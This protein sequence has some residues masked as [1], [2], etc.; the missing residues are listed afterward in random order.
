MQIRNWEDFVRFDAQGNLVLVKHYDG[1]TSER[2]SSAI[3]APASPI[4][5]TATISSGSLSDEDAGDKIAVELVA[6]QTYTWSYRPTETGGIQDPFLKLLGTDGT[7]VIVADDDGG[8]GRSSMISFTPTVGGTY[9]LLATSWYQAD[10]TAPDFQDNGNYTLAQW[11]PE[12]DV[13][14]TTTGAPSLVLGTN[15]GNIESTTDADTFQFD[16]AAGTFYTFSY[17]GGIVG[18]DRGEAFG[19]IARLDLL[20]GS[21]NLIA[22]N[23]NFES[24]LSYLSE[25]A[26]T[27]YVR[28][29]GFEGTGGYTVD[30]QEVEFANRDPLEAL[31]WDSA[32][33]IETVDTTPGEDGGEVAYVY[34]APAGV[35]FGET[36][37]DGSP[38]TTYG[39]TTEQSTAVMHALQ[40]QYTPITGIEYRVTTDVNQATFRMLT[41]INEEYGARFYPNDVAEYG[42]QAG[43]GTFNLASGGFGTDPASLLPGGYSYAVILHE[44]GHAHG[45]AHPHD[46][47]GGSEVIP[48]VTGSTGSLGIYDLN[49]GVYTVMS[50][51]DGWQTHPDGTLEYSRQT[52]DNG[53][54]E[55]LGA[56]DIAVLQERYGVHA[57][58]DTDTVYDLTQHQKIASYST[59]WDSGGN[60][61]IAYKGG[62]NAHIDLLA[63]TLDYTPT[64][65]GVVSY[66]SGTFGGYT[67]AGDVVIENATGGSGHD[68]L[69]GNDANNVLTGNNGNDTLFGRDGNDT[70]NGGNGKDDLR[71]DVGDDVLNGGVGRDILNG[72]A[73]NDT[74]NGGADVDLFVFEDAGTDTIVGYQKGEKLD[75]SEF[76]VT[77]D[78]VTI[79]G[80]TVTVDLGVDDLTILGANGVTMSNIVF[81]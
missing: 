17:S 70:L 60:D 4:D 2:T 31:N 59:I 36:E 15:Y 30:V 80:G 39:W 33:N 79:V 53:W 20:D 47:G 7:T 43:I 74:L 26:G 21:G 24:G 1:H 19:N 14:A 67:I 58:N 72:G 18:D 9:Y 54:S 48:G 28:V 73:G 77:S 46:N 22:T 12:A 55:T 23:L 41:T 52:R 32:A 78:N 45:V 42:E 65:G 49:Q 25:A 10:P 11:S 37:A 16:V 5:A 69:L 64:G 61:T 8:Y 40:T 81:G 38:M 51:N 71:G 44:F 6:G 75:L 3:S 63:A 66:I 34:F 13:G 50:Y 56:F 35:N 29:R 27:V 68:T 76:G 62:Q 57:Y